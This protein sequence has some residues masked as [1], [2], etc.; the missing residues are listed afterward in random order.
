MTTIQ[1]RLHTYR[2]D[3]SDPEQKATYEALTDTLTDTPGRGHWMHSHGGGSH[4]PRGH[5]ARHVE[6]ET[7]HPF[8]NQWDTVDGCR[9]FDWAEDACLPNRNIKQGHYLDITPEMVE[10]RQRRHVC[11]YCGHK[12]NNASGTFCRKCLGSQYLKETELHLLRM[13]PVAEFLPDRAPLTAAE[14]AMLHPLWVKRQKASQTERLKVRVQGQRDK[15]AKLVDEARVQAEKD[16]TEAAMKAEAIEFLLDHELFSLPDNMIYYS[17]T[18]RFAFGWRKKLTKDE[19]SA[20]LDVVSEF[21]YDYD[22]TD[23]RF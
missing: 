16:I 4:G 23:P 5:E 10:L 14:L 1:T 2:F 19:R 18:G 7:A 15:A 22:I 8:S 3:V 9:V 13:L 12:E 21:P 17:H 6:L 11:G 20:L